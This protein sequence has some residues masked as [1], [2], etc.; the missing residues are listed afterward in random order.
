ME[1]PIC[2]TCGNPE[3]QCRKYV[4]HPDP[5]NNRKQVEV[6]GWMYGSPFLGAI[7]VVI[8]AVIIVDAWFIS[9]PGQEDRF[10]EALVVLIVSVFVLAAV[11]VG[12]SMVISRYPVVIKCR[13]PV[14]GHNWPLEEQE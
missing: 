10:W 4:R 14:C 13:C 1:P 5:D 7:S 8:L 3:T 9:Q 11:W 12:K 6:P 2:P